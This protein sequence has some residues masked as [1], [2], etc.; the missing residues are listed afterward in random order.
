MSLFLTLLFSY[1]YSIISNRVCL[2]VTTCIAELAISLEEK[3]DLSGIQNATNTKIHLPSL[4]NEDFHISHGPKIS[5]PKNHKTKNIH[6]QDNKISNDF[7]EIENKNTVFQEIF[8]QTNQTN[9]SPTEVRRPPVDSFID[10]LIE[11][12]EAVLGTSSA[13]FTVQDILKQELESLL[14]KKTRDLLR[15]SGNPA[16]WPEFIEKF[17][18]RVRQ[19]SSFDN[20]LRILRL[21]S[22]L[23][24]EAKRV[25]AAIGS[26]GIF[27]ATALKTLKKTLVT[28]YL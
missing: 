10:Q 15:F 23:D 12:K 17:F 16:E 5:S 20:N 24:G 14:E 25:I 11:G 8:S 26:N 1:Q 4:S 6:F 2:R 27:Y 13:S 21:I 7:D 19:K 3:V 22:V 9:F 18:S 28:L